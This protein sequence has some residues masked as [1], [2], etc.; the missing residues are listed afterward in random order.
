MAVKNQ[1]LILARK[2]L[3]ALTWRKIL[4]VF[5]LSFIS[6]VI[7]FA[8]L[9]KKDTYPEVATIQRYRPTMGVSLSIQNDIESIVKKSPII[10]GIQIITIN[11]QNN[12]QLESHS[13]FDDLTARKIH[14]EY[15]V[16]KV[17]DI[18]LFTDNKVT[19]RRFL[20]LIGG[21]FVCTSFKETA[22]YSSTPQLKSVVTDVCSMAI[23]PYH[24]DFSGIFNIYLS[25]HPTKDDTERLFLL[26]REFSLKI[27]EENKH[28]KKEDNR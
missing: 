9:Y 19:N 26:S 5:V 7:V 3:G 25:G 18:P 27:Y 28:A 8:W 1:H 11:F 10:V 17:F 24:G 14:E 12:I 16:N 20:R 6:I 23:P 21:E 15:L 13:Y 22:I 2:F 4:S